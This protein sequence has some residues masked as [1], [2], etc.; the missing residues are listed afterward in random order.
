MSL[1]TLLP[2]MSLPTGLKAAP[3]EHALKMKI[4][5]LKA[6]VCKLKAKIREVNQ[7]KTRKACVNISDEA[8]EETLTSQSI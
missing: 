5:S 3:K 2:P 4:R 6:Q 1:T 7:L 8:V